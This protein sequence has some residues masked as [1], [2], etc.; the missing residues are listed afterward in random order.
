MQSIIINSPKPQSLHANQLNWQMS[1]DRKHYTHH[2]D[3]DGGVVT[4]TLA[5]VV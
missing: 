2:S 5:H 1:A 4:D 3:Q